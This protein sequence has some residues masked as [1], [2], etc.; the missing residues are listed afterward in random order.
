MQCRFGR[1]EYIMTKEFEKNFD[2]LS[3]EDLENVAGAGQAE[4]NQYL[5]EMC[6]KYNTTRDRV[7][8]YMSPA[9]KQQYAVLQHS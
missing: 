6:K 2:N 4:A 1:K 5:A 3:N 8:S 9:E 7:M